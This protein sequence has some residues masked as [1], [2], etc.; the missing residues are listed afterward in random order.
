MDKKTMYF[1]M[2]LYVP[3]KAHEKIMKAVTRQGPVSIKLDLTGTPRDKIYVT[4]GQKKKIQDAVARG[5]K[6]L[7]LRLSVR[8]AKHNIQSRRISWRY[9]CGSV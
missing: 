8:Q 3:V 1:P 9:T 6:D 5:K 4:S 2:D 7:T